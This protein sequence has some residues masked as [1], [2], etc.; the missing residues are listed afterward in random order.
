MADSISS[1]EN[2]FGTI[3]STFNCSSCCRTEGSQKAAHDD[4]LQRHHI[5]ADQLNHIEACGSGQ[6]Q[7]SEAYVEF[8]G[9]IRQSLD[10]RGSIG[11]NGHPMPPRF[12][13]PGQRPQQLQA[14]PLPS[15]FGRTYR[16]APPPVPRAAR[17]HS[18]SAPVREE[19]KREKRYRNQSAF[20]LPREPP[21]VLIKCHTVASPN[22]VP[23]PTSFVV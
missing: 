20:R 14:D 9:A 7:V 1:I 4:H 23:C 8:V 11:Q 17:H 16:A 2:G 10:R 5:V 18:L 21:M 6:V 12:Q 15:K 19:T 22:P 13:N 3:A